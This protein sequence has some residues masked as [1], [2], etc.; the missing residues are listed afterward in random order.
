[1]CK[2]GVCT[3]GRAAEGALPPHHNPGM[4]ILQLFHT[5]GFGLETS[6]PAAGAV[7]L[8]VPGRAQQGST[9]S[10]WFLMASHMCPHARLKWPDFPS[11]GS[12]DLLGARFGL[13]R[14]WAQF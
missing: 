8:E 6:G 5:P 4:Q 11:L 7:P 13:S 2:V 9:C 1:M 12:R 14:G 10:C 3:E